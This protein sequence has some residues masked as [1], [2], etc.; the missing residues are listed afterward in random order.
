MP[1]APPGAVLTHAAG[2]ARIEATLTGQKPLTKLNHIIHITSFDERVRVSFVQE[3][4]EGGSLEIE[5]KVKALDDESLGRAV[6]EIMRRISEASALLD[7]ALEMKV[8]R[9]ASPTEVP[10]EV[11]SG[12]IEE[13]SEA[14]FS[15]FTDVLWSVAPTKGDVWLGVGE[16]EGLA[17]FLGSHPGWEVV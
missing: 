17:W 3:E 9:E 14:G 15:V 5:G 4:G 10:Q 16:D 1:A 6:E 7:A 2:A 11:V 13:L 8:V 12:L